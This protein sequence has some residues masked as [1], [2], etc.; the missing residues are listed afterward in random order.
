MSSNGSS[1]PLDLQR[2]LPTTPA[3]I[4]RL[5]ELRLPRIDTSTY[6]ETIATLGHVAPDQLRKR[7]GPARGEPFRLD[8][9]DRR[10]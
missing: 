5:H 4:A 7:P 10:G 3:D 9:D 6:L 2:G 8:T 1:E